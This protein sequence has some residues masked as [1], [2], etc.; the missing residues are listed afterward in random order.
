[1]KHLTIR[2]VPPEIS[3][4]LEREKRRRAQSLNKTVL[5]LLQSALGVAGQARP[6]NGLERLAGSW[7]HDEYQRFEEA[8][9]CFE[10][11]DEEYWH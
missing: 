2:N 9:A 10:Q 3:N 1:M 5:E 11:I 6:S 4:A 7:N 8:T